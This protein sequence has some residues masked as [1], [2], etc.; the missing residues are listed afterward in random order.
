MAKKWEKEEAIRGKLRNVIRQEIKSVKEGKWSKIM[1]SVRKGSK[2]GPW[3]IIVYKGKKVLHQRRVKI[4]QQIPAHYE[5]VLNLKDLAPGIKI[6]IEDKYGERV[7]T[8]SVNEKRIKNSPLRRMITST[9]KDLD[10]KFRKKLTKNDINRVASYITSK[11][12]YFP[13]GLADITADY[14]Y[15]YKLGKLKINGAIQ[16]TINFQRG[17]PYKYNFRT[18]KELESVNESDLG[19]TYKKGKTVKVTH[20]KSGKELVIIDKPNVRKEYEKIG[21]FDEGKE[22]WKEATTSVSVPGYLSPQAFSKSTQ[23]AIDFDDEDDEKNESVNENVKTHTIQGNKRW[24]IKI[25]IPILKN[26]GIKNLKV[27]TVGKTNFFYFKITFDTDSN[28]LK[29]LDK[30]LKRKNKKSNYGGIVETLNESVN[31]SMAAPFRRRKSRG[32]GRP[33]KVGINELSMAP[34]SSP[35]AKQQVDRDVTIMS[36]YLGKASQQVIKTMMDGVKSGQYDAMDLQRGIKTGPV[37]RTHFGETDFIQQLWHKVRS[38][39]RRYSKR[40]KLR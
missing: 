26:Y 29:K 7:Y 38:G 1:K 30:E 20:K 8:E 22:N 27:N 37:K 25:A 10:K 36:N 5:D 28:T 3:T 32:L 18:G 19:L 12:R 24:M 15:A 21:F 14:F 9:F 13:K 40:G 17:Y 31:E 34:F 39:F 2:S 4:L 6:G 11:N 35:E 33:M 23:K 16:G